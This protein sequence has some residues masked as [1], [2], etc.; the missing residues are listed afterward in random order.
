M[1][2]YVH[3]RS[4]VENKPRKLFK[5]GKAFRQRRPVIPDS[6]EKPISATRS[7]RSIHKT[8]RIL[9]RAIAAIHDF[10]ESVGRKGLS[11]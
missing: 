8:P 1:E 9:N 6:V 2:K 11:F 4:I 3:G 7:N 5:K 10:L